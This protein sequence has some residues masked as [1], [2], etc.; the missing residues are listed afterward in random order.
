MGNESLCC[1]N[2]G[3]DDIPLPIRFHFDN[4]HKMASSYQQN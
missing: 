2:S 1:K 3:D 4:K